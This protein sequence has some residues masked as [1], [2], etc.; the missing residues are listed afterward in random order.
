MKS[1]AVSLS[2]TREMETQ[3]TGQMIQHRP[4]P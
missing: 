1:Y 4:R 3:R 2:G